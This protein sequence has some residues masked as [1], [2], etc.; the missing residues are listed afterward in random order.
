MI[1]PIDETESDAVAETD[2]DGPFI[3]GFHWKNV[4]IPFDVCLIKTKNGIQYNL[5][6]LDNNSP[7]HAK[8]VMIKSLDELLVKL[9]ALLS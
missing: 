5:F 8:D 1:T 3:A 2:D 4:R 6:V 9:A 7:D